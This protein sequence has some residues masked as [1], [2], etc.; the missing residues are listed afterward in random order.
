[1]D[2]RKKKNPSQLKL[3]NHKNT[4]DNKKPNWVNI[5]TL[6]A[7][8]SGGILG[9]FYI[10]K[11][12]IE[13]K[14]KLS[15]SNQTLAKA[16][17]EF[18]NL[19]SQLLKLELEIKKVRDRLDISERKIIISAN[20]M[21]ILSDIQPN[22]SVTSKKSE[23]QED[24]LRLVFMIKNLGKHPCVVYKPKILAATQWILG[25]KEIQGKLKAGEDYLVKDTYP[26][27]Y[28]PPGVE[29]DYT[30]TI[31]IKKKPLN[32][33]IF[34]FIT[35]TVRTHPDIINVTEKFLNDLLTKDEILKL[36]SKNFNNQ[37]ILNSQ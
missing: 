32:K 28:F 11:P 33:T 6:F 22:F 23:Y 29:D 27:G 35:F 13:I 30:V 24:K 5:C 10:H 18:T 3:I 4:S 2:Y 9:Y 31:S 15:I 37:Y 8:I 19:R 36:A 14:N 20:A 16:N 1:M 7:M 34:F 21:E 26:I 12:Q 25:R 17:E